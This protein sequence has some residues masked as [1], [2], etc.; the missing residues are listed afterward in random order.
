PPTDNRP[1]FSYAVPLGRLPALMKDWKALQT[2]H[3]GLLTLFGLLVLSGLF[4]VLLF[5]GPLAIQRAGVLGAPDRG[6]RVRAL[7]YFAAIGGGFVCV[8]RAVLYELVFFLGHPVY[9]LSAVLLALLL[10]TGFGSL[11]T[12]RIA[13]SEAA[14]AARNRGVILVVFLAVYSV[15]L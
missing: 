10:W 8:V 4:G 6:A 3:I 1:F 11:A 7:L 9:A 5:V 15:A 13:S 14:S 2:E 12:T